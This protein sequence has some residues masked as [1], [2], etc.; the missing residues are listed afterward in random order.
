MSKDSDK[1]IL[2]GV[3]G[4]GAF[5]LMQRRPVSGTLAPSQRQGSN[6]AAGWA[7]AIA[8]GISGLFGNRGANSAGASGAWASNPFYS[9]YAAQGATTESQAAHWRDDDPDV[10]GSI[11]DYASSARDGIAFSPPNNVDP[12][13]YAQYLG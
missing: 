6:S 8:S 12:W 10:N 1:I 2:L 5:W 9:K 4:L 7:Q 11:A 3:I 13:A